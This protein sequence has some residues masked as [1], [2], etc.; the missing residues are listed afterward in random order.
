MHE[1]LAGHAHDE[2]RRLAH[3][4]KGA[5][6]SY[7]YPQLTDACRVLEDAAIAKDVAAENAGLAKV[8]V[9]IRAIQKAS[10]TSPSTGATP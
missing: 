4:L 8:E 9:L 7:G 3:K 2:L 5:G 1:T 10:I 6:G